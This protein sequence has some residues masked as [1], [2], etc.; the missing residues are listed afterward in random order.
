[1]R[2]LL[3][4]T[5]LG[6]LALMATP[7]TAFYVVPGNTGWLADDN[8]IS[9]ST[10]GPHIDGPAL[11]IQGCL[12]GS[13]ST[14]VNVTTTVPHQ[15]YYDSNGQ[16]EIMGG[17]VQHD[18]T[19]YSD[20]TF[21][22]AG[23]T[24]GSIIMDIGTS[25]DGKV[26]FYADGVPYGTLFDVFEKGSN[27]FTIA[28]ADIANGGIPTGAFTTVGYALFLTDGTTHG[29]IA[30]NTKQVRIGYVDGVPAPEPASLALLGSALL[31]LG[32]ARGMRRR[33]TA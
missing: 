31:G 26:Q 1:M 18:P 24:F 33:T 25:F 22:V 11:L 29:D 10:C 21:Q 14:Q 16:A 19:H 2:K 9:G 27:F 7:A 13:H 20:L 23:H 32:A 28:D 17:S 5:A 6:C 30:D 8:L 12:N 15:I 3:A 4:A